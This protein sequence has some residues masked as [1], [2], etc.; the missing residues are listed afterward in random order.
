LARY[1][2]ENSFL[3][4]KFSDARSLRKKFCGMRLSEDKDIVVLCGG[5][6]LI[7]VMHPKVPLVSNIFIIIKKTE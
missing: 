6:S 3:N 2:Y 1:Y 4:G 5:H 7:R